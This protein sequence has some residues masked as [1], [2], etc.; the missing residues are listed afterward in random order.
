MLFDTEGRVFSMI[1]HCLYAICEAF[2]VFCMQLRCV[3]VAG[4]IDKELIQAL[5]TILKANVVT[6][7]ALVLLG[8]MGLEC[9]G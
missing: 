2:A 6:F 7:A 9:V 5:V 3:N 4:E 1:V 8:P